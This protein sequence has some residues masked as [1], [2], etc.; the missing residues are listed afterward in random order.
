[1]ALSRPI[2]ERLLEKVEKDFV[3]GCWLW[4]GSTSNGYGYIGYKNKNLRVHIVSYLIFKGK[5]PIGFDIHHKCN[6][7]NCCNPDH[8]E[9]IT[10]LENV[11]K[12]TS[13][14]A[15]AAQ[16]TQ[17]INGHPFDQIYKGRR[18][19]GTCAKNNSKRQRERKR[20][21]NEI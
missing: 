3:K 12:S 20:K 10:H 18:R 1:M 9:A 2:I 14:A 4:R 15:I 16:Q 6:V 17:C 8:L 21:L 13:P 19:C 11:L 5:F 7:R